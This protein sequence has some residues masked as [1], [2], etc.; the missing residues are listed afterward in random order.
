MNLKD[1]GMSRQSLKH[2]QLVEVETQIKAGCSPLQA[3]RAAQRPADPLS[4]QVIL[5]LYALLAFD[6]GWDATR[7]LAMQLD[8]HPLA[9]AIGW[10]NGLPEA[11][12]FRMLGLTGRFQAQPYE[13]GRSDVSIS[14]LR[15]VVGMAK[16]SPLLFD[17]TVRNQD[18]LFLVEVTEPKSM[19]GSISELKIRGKYNSDFRN[20]NSRAVIIYDLEDLV[21]HSDSSRISSIIVGGRFAGNYAK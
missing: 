4:T 12:V 17:E 9:F 18:K 5:G 1:R 7:S 16:G 13:L 10:A 2:P 14:P 21:L 8:V 19:A 11:E 6:G 20:I 15:P 3:L